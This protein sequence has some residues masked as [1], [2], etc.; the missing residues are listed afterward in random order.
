[1]TPRPTVASPEPPSVPRGPSAEV[2]G[3]PIAVPSGD[4]VSNTALR[5]ASIAA[6]CCG[7]DREERYVQRRCQQSGDPGERYSAE[8][9]GAHHVVREQKP[10]RRHPAQPAT[11]H[12]RTDHA[13][14]RVRRHRATDPQT[15]RG[16]RRELDRQPRGRDEAHSVPEVRDRQPQGQPPEHAVGEH[17]P[18]GRRD[19]ASEKHLRQRSSWM[20][21]RLPAES[22]TAQS[23][24]PYGCSVGS[25]TTSAS[26]ACSRSKAPSRSL[27]ASRSVA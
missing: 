6:R 8:K 7:G 20:R 2:S 25:C 4:A 27:V 22:R 19:K 5:A 3:P 15:G 17:R 23:R 16:L 21:T 9:D 13:R 1:M 18:I 10:L 12:Q 14:Q 24:T 11:E 26:P